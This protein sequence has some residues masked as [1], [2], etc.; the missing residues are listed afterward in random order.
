[1]IS[2][3]L[4]TLLVISCILIV[5]CTRMTVEKAETKV[6]S[7]LER[8]ITKNKDLRHGILLVHSDSLGLK[9]KF[10]Y[11]TT[12]KQQKP[13]SEDHTFHIASIGKT[14]VSALIARLYEEG[15][16]S[17]DDPISKYLSDD[18]L[19]NLHVFEGKSYSG[20]ITISHLLNHTSG[21][22]DYFEEKSKDGKSMLELA[23][24]EPDRFFTPVE[25]IQW[26][27]DNLE[28]HF[29]PGEKFHYSDTGYQLLGLIIEEITGKPLH[30]NLNEYIFGPLNMIHSYQL[31]YSE[32]MKKSPYPIA[33]IYID[34]IE[35]STYESISLDWASGGIVS[36][37]E[38][39]LLF[40]QALVKNTLLKEET[41]DKWKNWTKFG[42]GIDYGYGLV[43][44]SFKEMTFFLSDKMNMWGNWGS[45]STF[46]FY[47]PTYDVYII[48]AFNQSNFVQNQIQFMVKVIGIVSKLS[49]N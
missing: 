32:P 11:G 39:L 23:L 49:D 20:K 14:I 38:D 2:K 45:T 25:T 13:I 24:D 4:L 26:A 31:F 5:G 6:Q 16:I 28:A 34:D 9:W 29:P 40:H 36:N 44:L 30:E 48:G 3:I 7:L 19:N 42:R 18:I 37:T 43:S 15:K 27:K 17:Y 21:I 47:N 10:A 41:F 1:M 46:M 12:G 22:P 35:V 8:T 33:Y